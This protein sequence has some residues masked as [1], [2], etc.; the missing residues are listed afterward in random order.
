M[1]LLK[2]ND[3]A[4]VSDRRLV[5]AADAAGVDDKTKI[6]LSS[7]GEKTVGFCRK[8]AA[9]EDVGQIYQNDLRPDRLDVGAVAKALGC[10]ADYICGL[11]EELQPGTADSLEPDTAA[12]TEWWQTGPAP[13]D[14]RYLC[15][16]DLGTGAGDLHEQQCDSRDGVWEAYGRPVADMFTVKAWY[17]LPAKWQSWMKLPEEDEK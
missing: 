7:Y 17:P 15:L 9:G 6:K 2:K 14:G 11:T 12:P 16:V 4:V 8:A 3:F 1:L 5:K 13:G 10:S